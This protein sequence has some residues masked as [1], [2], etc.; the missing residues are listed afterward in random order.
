[1]NDVYPILRVLI[2]SDYTVFIDFED[3]SLKF[4]EGVKHV[5]KNIKT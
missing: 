4:K 5:I 2:G 3:N 1:M